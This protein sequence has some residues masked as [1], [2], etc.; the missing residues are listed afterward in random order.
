MMT[1]ALSLKKRLL[2]LSVNLALSYGLFVF[3]TN[4]WAISG[5]QP[6]LWL[7][8]AWTMWSVRLLSNPWFVPP[9]DTLIS[10]VTTILLLVTVTIDPLPQP[11]TQETKLFG[12]AFSLL[13]GVLAVAALI[14]GPPAQETNLGRLTFRTLQ[15]FGPSEL[16]FTFP[17]LVSILHFAREPAKLAVL[18]VFWIVVVIM[19]PVERVIL[20][21][22]KLGSEK[23]KE[24]EGV[25]EVVRV[26]SPGLFRL[27]VPVEKSWQENRLLR[28]G[29]PDGV[30]ELLLTLFVQ[31]K[32]TEKI[33]TA[34]RLDQLQ[35]EESL[36]S[37][38]AFE[39]AENRDKD[40]Y[41]SKL[42][43]IQNSSLVGF[44][45]ENSSINQIRFEI[46]SNSDLKEGDIVFVSAS[47][48][49]V[50]YQI[51]GASTTEE[52]FEQN[53]RGTHVVTASQIGSFDKAEGFKKFRW[54]PLMNSPVFK[55]D[56]GAFDQAAPSA[57]E[58]VLGQLPNTKVD[59]R[60]KVSDIVEYH[61]A[62]LG[63]TGTGKTEVAL[64]IIRAAVEQGVKCFCVDFTGDYQ[65]RLAD[66]DPSFPAPDIKKAA[67]LEKQLATVD[68]YGF[69]AG[70]NKAAAGKILREIR[71]ETK[72]QVEEFLTSDEDR[73]AIFE[74]ADITNSRAGLRITEV[75]LSEIMEWSRRN[76]KKQPVLICLEE[77][78]TIVPE[79]IGSGLDGETKWVVE[80]IG[81]IA[82]QGRKY[83]V[84]LLVITQR[85]AL[86]SKTILSQCN[87]FITHALVD[88]T[89][90]NFLEN[91]LSAQ[92]SRVVP[93]LEKFE[94]L[95]AGKAINSERPVVVKRHFDPEKYKASQDIKD[96][97]P[98]SEEPVEEA[99]EGGRASARPD[100][101]YIARP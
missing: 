79:A 95:A 93:N 25:A 27:K 36:P 46:S 38:I 64:D 29:R 26:D 60:A 15:I 88:Q 81:Q 99:T 31:M 50:F 87:T 85:T 65:S 72:N 8:A 59:I 49:P 47:D 3:T 90:L 73:V 101:P 53:P 68:I 52:F 94:F 44:I 96:C 62:V 61:A 11:I 42:S 57:E 14:N 5:N 58:M 20:L 82:L 30:N 80:R 4:S 43:G 39:D 13:I 78:H 83:G 37:G 21:I 16:L 48:Q 18:T 55:S 24:S 70:D 12:L 75:F 56:N 100:G 32:G 22:D 67:E 41:L 77:A 98:K 84:G 10:S 1:S 54:L 69:K 2:A 9:K 71:A 89:S 23:P 86:V 45:V 74:L 35:D 66:L 17:A 19:K 76:R 7:V 34:L 63:V 40:G 97:R 6:S 91:I 92:H 28:V 33:G 51:D